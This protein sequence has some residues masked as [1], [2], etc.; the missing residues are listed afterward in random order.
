VY[1]I[2]RTAGIL[3]YAVL[4]KNCTS[5]AFTAEEFQAFCSIIVSRLGL[6]FQTQIEILNYC[7]EIISIESE[8]YT[9]NIS[10]FVENKDIEIN[11]WS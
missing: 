4:P 8:F 9:K 3:K 5:Y 10:Y 7:S 6:R 11:L 1:P 2:S